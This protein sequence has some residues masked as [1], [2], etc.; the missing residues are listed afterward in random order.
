[1]NANKLFVYGTLMVDDVMSAV[2]R[3]GVRDLV[4][5][6]AVLSDHCRYAVRGKSY[7]AVVPRLGG[8]VEGI[9]VEGITSEDLRRLDEFE[10]D[11][12]RRVTCFVTPRAPSPA[13]VEA[14]VYLWADDGRDHLEGEW[15]LEENFIPIMKEQ[16]SRWNFVVDGSEKE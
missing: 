4:K 1:M 7:P 11:E 15:S 3:R 8:R 5:R 12:Y 10:G 14:F 2:L 6:D 9:I 13:L 16:L